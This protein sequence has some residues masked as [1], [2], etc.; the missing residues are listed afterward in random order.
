MLEF[1]CNTEKFKE[2]KD[3]W[4]YVPDN[5]IDSDILPAI[6]A[7]NSCPDLVT[8]YC[9]AGH[10][11]FHD[12]MHYAG[13]I[14]FAVKNLNGLLKLLDFYFKLGHNQKEIDSDFHSFIG[15]RRCTIRFQP[16]GYIFNSEK[17]YFQFFNETAIQI[18]KGES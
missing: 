5:C 11:H 9:C 2:L 1:Q 4:W 10:T 8:L 18:F 3:L 16:S 17:E 15:Y 6:E 12:T 13:Y 14:C 7:I